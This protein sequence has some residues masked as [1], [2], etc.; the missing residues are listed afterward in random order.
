MTSKSEVTDD[1]DAFPT[2]RVGVHTSIAGSFDQAAEKA[3]TLTCTA[4]Q[5][6]SSSP[7]M[8][9]SR[10]PRAEEIAAMASLRRRYDLYPLVIHANYLI[11]LASPEPALRKQS[12]DAFRGEIG[13]AAALGAE[14]LVLHPGSFRQ[15]TAEMGIRTLASSIREVSRKTPFGGVTLLLENTAGQGS[16]LGSTFQE[17]QDMLALLEGLP[18]GCCIDTA[19]CFAAGMDISSQAGLQSIIRSLEETI[20]LER[21]KVI[22]ANDSRSALGSHLDRHEHIGKGGIGLEG[23]RRIVNHPALRDKT[24]ILETPVDVPGDDRRNMEAIRSVRLP[25]PQRNGKQQIKQKQSGFRTRDKVSPST[26][27][28]SAEPQRKAALPSA[29]RKTSATRQQTGTRVRQSGKAN[30]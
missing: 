4:F 10:E 14:Y 9:K 12:V 13:R 22:H 17:L 28:S 19:H 15:A 25:S 21:V 30:R 27:Y 2:W 20:G 16:C 1:T 5:I 23:F 8:W 18:V 26:R 7:R 11:N 3:H 29:R 24:F 6:F